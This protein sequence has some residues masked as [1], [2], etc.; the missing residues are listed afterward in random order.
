MYPLVPWPHK[1]VKTRGTSKLFT[2]F[3]RFCVEGKDLWK[4]HCNP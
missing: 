4:E 3:T 1:Q 2:V